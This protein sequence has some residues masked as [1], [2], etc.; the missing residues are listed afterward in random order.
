VPWQSGHYYVFSKF[1]IRAVVPGESG[2]FALY[3]SQERVLI[4]ESPNLRRTLLRLYA[5]MLRFG[6][7]SPAGFTFEVC[8]APLRRT[9]LRELLAEHEIACHEQRANIVLYG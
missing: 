6:F 3:A 9:R 8:P 1:I 4:G 2:I 5:D 7:Y